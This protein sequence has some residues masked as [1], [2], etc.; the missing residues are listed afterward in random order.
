[1]FTTAK[2]RIIFQSSKLFRIKYANLEATFNIQRRLEL[3]EENGRLVEK[4]WR[5]AKNKLILQKNILN[6]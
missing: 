5:I 3:A 2:L 4:I 1:M 6:I